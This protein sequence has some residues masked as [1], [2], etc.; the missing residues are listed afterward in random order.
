MATEFY[1]KDQSLTSKV[2]D[3]VLK[4]GHEIQFQEGN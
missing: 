1:S 3:T 4:T 2:L